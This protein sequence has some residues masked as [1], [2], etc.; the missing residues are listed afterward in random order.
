MMARVANLLAE[1]DP[2]RLLHRARAGDVAARGELFALY[3]DYLA[4]L[5]RLQGRRRLKGKVDAQDLVQETFLKAHDRFHQF[6]GVTEAELLAWLRQ[7]LA[8]T[9]ANLVRH[10]LGSKGRDQ[11]LER[12]LTDEL[13]RSSCCLERNLIAPQSSPSQRAA[14]REQ[15]VLLAN[16]LGQLPEDYREAVILRHLEGLSFPEVAGRMGRTVDSVKKLWARGLARLR[17]LLRSAP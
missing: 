10:Y 3:G 17:D 13:G 12:A 14:R 5:A 2:E 15:A 9:I 11:R 4:L 16:V 7:I 8:N 1:A 6:R